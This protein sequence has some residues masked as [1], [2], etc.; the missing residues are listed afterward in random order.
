M[1]SHALSLSQ[2]HFVWEDQL[3]V[4][5]P[6]FNVFLHRWCFP[7]SHHHNL[8][9]LLKLFHLR[10]ISGLAL[11][12][13][14]VISR[15]SRIC[16]SLLQQN[17][18][19][20]RLNHRNLHLRRRQVDLWYHESFNLLAPFESYHSR[21]FLFYQRNFWALDAYLSFNISLLLIALFPFV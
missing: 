19:L 13:L 5:F 11:Y 3:C 14:C 9:S 10:K 1:L 8:I 18:H 21:T 6:Q 4:Q 17:R 16:F 15:I 12:P 20:S 2:V 7:Y